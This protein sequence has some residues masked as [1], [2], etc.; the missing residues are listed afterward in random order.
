MGEIT[1]ID[2]II[3]DFTNVQTGIAGK[4]AI[5]D[6]GQDSEGVKVAGETGAGKSSSTR[7]LFP[8][9]LASLAQR[10]GAI[11]VIFV[12]AGDEAKLRGEI[13]PLSALNSV[14]S[15][16]LSLKSARRRHMR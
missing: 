4:I 11:G 8:C 16:D 7:S 15:V 5:V 6:L 12:Y 3:T 2:A 14:W 9:E 10:H 1:S 13:L